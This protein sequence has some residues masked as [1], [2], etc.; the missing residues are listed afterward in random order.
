MD[1][2]VSTV[3]SRVLLGLLGQLLSSVA[4]TELRT[5]RQLGYIV[6][7]AAALGKLPNVSEMCQMCQ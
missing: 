5:K 6:S 3:K 7:A 4:F 2:G 1:V